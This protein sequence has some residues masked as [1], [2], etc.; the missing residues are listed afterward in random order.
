[1]SEESLEGGAVPMAAVPVPD[2]VSDSPVET[3]AAP[4]SPSPVETNVETAP[5]TSPDPSS[6]SYDDFGWDDWGGTVSTLPESIQPWAQKVYDSRQ[7]HVDTQV[8]EGL[9]E[10]TRIKD[11]YNALLDGHDDPR[12]NDLST[13]HNALQ[14]QYDG[15]LS[16]STD[17]EQALVQFRQ[18]MSESI[19]Q[20]ATRYADWFEETHGDLFQSPESAAKLESLLDSGWDI[21]LTPKLMGLSEEALVTA[22]K[23]LAEGVPPKYA[24]Q[25]GLQSL[26]AKSAPPAPR[27]AARIT[28][29]ATSAPSSP[30]QRRNSQGTKVSS[31]DDM[32]LLAAANAVKR[33]SGGRR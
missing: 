24:I 25:L 18:E 33:H 2:V 32:R 13:Q 29:G 19:E 31:I 6:P 14:V 1:M 10:S 16:K 11:I 30:N 23:A 17:S 4:S 20:E 27:P 5:Q 7:T 8:Q 9:A 22:S 15:L 26:P 12:Y 28:S 3:S 21:G